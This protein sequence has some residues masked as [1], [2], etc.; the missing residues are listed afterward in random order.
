MPRPDF[1]SSSPRAALYVVLAVLV[2]TVTSGETCN[3]GEPLPGTL[4]LTAE[5]DLAAQMVD[6][7]DRFL[8]REI[9]A[10]LSGSGGQPNRE[11][12]AHII[13]ATDDRVSF[14]A[15]ELV[16]T[17]DSPPKVADAEAYEVF[18]VR[19]PV[20]Q[21]REGGIVY[22][23]GLLVQPKKRRPLADVVAVPDADTTPEMPHTVGQTGT[24]S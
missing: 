14:E 3:A 16:G 7:I 23:E 22:G 12:L 24:S 19:W 2:L 20:L 6:G 13:G 5:G 18:A 4:P 1:I 8:L 9:S 15:P 17:I 21:G 10:T 11:R